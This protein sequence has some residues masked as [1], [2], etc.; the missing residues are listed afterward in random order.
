MTDRELEEAIARRLGWT[1][2]HHGCGMSPDAHTVPQP[3]RVPSYLTDRNAAQEIVTHFNG[4]RRTGEA[5][6][7]LAAKFAIEICGTAGNEF[8]I[9]I[10]ATPRQ[11]CD[12]ACK[13]WGLEVSNGNG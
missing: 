10:C 1:L 8:W 4:L 3:R 11:I 2:V 5:N 7:L 6:S 12:A 13:V 9:G